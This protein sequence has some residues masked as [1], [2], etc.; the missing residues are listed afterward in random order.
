MK[1]LRLLP[2][3]ALAGLLSACVVAPY[4]PYGYD[5]SGEAVADIP[6]PAPYAEVVPV[7]PY[8]GA[9]WI[10]GYWGWRA[11]RHHWVPGYWDRP[12]PGYYWRPYRWQPMMGR[13]HLSPGGW[14][15]SH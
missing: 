3:L 12:R 8:A 15:R 1:P 10:G 6:P 5:A 9:V 11:G 2:A 13:W 4:Y 14:A 7:V